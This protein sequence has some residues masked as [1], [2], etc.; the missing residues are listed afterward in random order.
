MHLPGLAVFDDERLHAPCHGSIAIGP[1]GASQTALISSSN[2]R[3]RH[4]SAARRA[5]DGPIPESG[6][7]RRHE[8]QIVLVLL[9]KTEAAEIARCQP[10]W[11]RC[12]SVRKHPQPVTTTK[13]MNAH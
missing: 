2:G 7:R 6:A 5:S 13:A 9:G 4:F 12:A 1:D 11:G 8:V 10:W 3:V